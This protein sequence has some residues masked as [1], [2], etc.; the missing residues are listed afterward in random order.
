MSHSNLNWALDSE[1]AEQPELFNG[2]EI[3]WFNILD[4]L[5]NLEPPWVV[6]NNHRAEEKICNAKDHFE[7]GGWM[8]PADVQGMVCDVLENAEADDKRIMLEGRHRLIAAIRLGETYAPF[9][10]PLD[11][12]DQLKST[13]DERSP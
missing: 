8:D 4:F 7:S 13:I 9:S 3:I 5:S 12:V 6:K 10:V 1:R 11:M 2:R